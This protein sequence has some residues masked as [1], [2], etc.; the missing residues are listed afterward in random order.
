MGKVELRAAS[1]VVR[2]VDEIEGKSHSKILAAVPRPDPKAIGLGNLSMGR[3]IADFD[4]CSEQNCSDSLKVR[5]KY[6]R[7]TQG[8]LV[9]ATVFATIAPTS[10]LP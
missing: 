7:W 4:T 8:L 6:S 1:A 5:A 9:S 2:C 3:R 10:N